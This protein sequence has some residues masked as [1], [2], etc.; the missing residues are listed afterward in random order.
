MVQFPLTLRSLRQPHLPHG[1]TRLQ[2]YAFF[3]FE[4]PAANWSQ[5][6]LSTNLHVVSILRNSLEM[7]NS[8]TRVSSDTNWGEV[9]DINFVGHHV[10]HKTG[11][12]SK[13]KS[14]S[15]KRV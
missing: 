15:V 4:V 8:K 9:C 7:D 2:E 1:A 14:H 11:F 10:P 5:T 3:A 12:S 13:S 6:C